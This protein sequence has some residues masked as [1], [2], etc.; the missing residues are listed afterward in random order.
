MADV[1]DINKVPYTGHMTTG[2]PYT[3]RTVTNPLTRDFVFSWNGKEYKIKAGKTETFPEFL[4]LH[5][6][7]KLA[8]EYFAEKNAPADPKENKI[9]YTISMV[10][11]FMKM[12]IDVPVDVPRPVGRP[13]ASKAKP[14][15]KTKTPD[16]VEE[17]PAPVTEEAI[18]EDHS[19]VEDDENEIPR[20]GDIADITDM[21]DP[22]EDDDDSDE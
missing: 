20:V 1:I 3:P 7:R 6:A 14:A 2:S 9:L 15:A 19:V 16:K 8:K 21:D 18:E 10:E 22:M 5:A 12:V 4:I 11:E 17:A 13:V